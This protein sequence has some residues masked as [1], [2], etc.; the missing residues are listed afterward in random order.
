MKPPLLT[1]KPIKKLAIKIDIKDDSGSSSNTSSMFVAE[2]DGKLV[3]P[4]AAP[5]K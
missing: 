5:A 4:V 2:K 3:I 1:M